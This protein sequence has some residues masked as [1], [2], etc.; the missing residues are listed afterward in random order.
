MTATLTPNIISYAIRLFA[1]C[2]VF[3]MSVSEVIAQ[4]RIQEE[5]KRSNGT[6]VHEADFG[7]YE[8]AIQQVHNRASAKDFNEQV[9][10]LFDCVPVY[11]ERTNSFS[12]E[13]RFSFEE[14]DIVEKLLNLGYSAVYFKK[15]KDDE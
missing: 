8:F 10:G 2:L 9:R 14:R 6:P 15:V 13:A 7:S 5:S 12:F 4:S 1:C 3:S 11:S